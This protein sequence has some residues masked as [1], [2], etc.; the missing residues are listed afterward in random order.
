MLCPRLIC[1]NLKRG[2]R[3][4]VFSDG[5]PKARVMIIGEAPER[6]E[7]QQGKPFVGRPGQ[8]LDKMFAAIGLDRASPD[9]PSTGFYVTTPNSMASARKPVIRRRQRSPCS[10]RF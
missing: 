8:L 5:N 9:D 7:D 6:E 4:L 2:A 3:N 10:S 1:V